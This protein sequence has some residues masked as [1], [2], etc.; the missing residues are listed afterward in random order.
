MFRGRTLVRGLLSTMSMRALAVPLAVVA[1]L[2]AV[3][4]CG[5]GAPGEPPPT[6]LRRLSHAELGNT[7][8]DLFP[9]VTIPPI[10][11]AADPEVYGFENNATAQ[12]PSPLLIEQYL[13]ITQSIAA[14]AMQRRDELIPCAPT[15][16]GDGCGRQVI[17]QLG[18]RA[19]RR[20]MTAAEIDRYE[21]YFE[22][23]RTLHNFDVAVR[24]VVQS[25]LLSPQF[26][27][28]LELTPAQPGD[29]RVRLDGYEMASRLSYLLWG[30]MPDEALFAAAAADELATP[31]QRE[32][33]ARRMLADPRARAMVV[34]FH[35]QWLGFDGLEQLNKDP[36]RYPQWTA[37]LRA[38]MREETER[39]IESVVFEGDGSLRTLLTRP[40]TWVDANLAELYGLELSP[41]DWTEVDLDPAQ[42]AGILTQASF[43]ASRAHARHPSP[44]LRG[45]FT[46]DRLLCQPLPPP[47]PGVNTTPPTDG[48]EPTTNR[49]RYVDHEAP[50]CIECHAKID[51]IGFGF[52]HYDAI[53]AFR[54]LDD[55]TAVDATGELVDT[56]VDGPFD[57]AIE[58]SQRLA[59]SETVR[60]CYVTQWF[61]AGFGR[62][63]VEGDA[64]TIDALDAAFAD[65][66]EDIRELL[67]AIATSDEL[68]HR[69]V[70][71]E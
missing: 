27:Y 12:A 39:F 45:V 16:P 4:G 54:E 59:G 43:L 38:S 6:P 33:Q 22:E 8:R 2:V 42:R 46:F 71:A 47:P 30:S 3:V 25:L 66:G 48:P 41:A 70:A 34:D 37:T 11:L 29:Q 36:G 49:E 13:S 28:R 55:G 62:G 64:A 56:D 19:F 67:I 14:A 53:G 57:G 63:E 15:G 7:V 23:Q 69:Y 40:R 18:P 52:E 32:A 58:L 17:A 21:T 5:D 26:L 24:L 68:A 51:G 44:V 60:R 1:A 9:G 20:P 65:A 35:R 61:R 50:G 10:E 31:A